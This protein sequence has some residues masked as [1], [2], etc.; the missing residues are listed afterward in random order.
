MKRPNFENEKNEDRKLKTEKTCF[1]AEVRDKL[2]RLPRSGFPIIRA[3]STFEFIKRDSA[4]RS[5]KDNFAKIQS[6]Y[7][8]GKHL[9]RLVLVSDEVM[10]GLETLKK[11]F[12]NFIEVLCH[13]K[14]HL[15][16][17]TIGDQSV[18]IN[19]I[20]LWG[21]P[22]I[23]KTEFV[24]ALSEVLC[25][26]MEKVNAA[27]LNGALALSGTEPQWGESAPGL[28]AQAMMRSENA[29]FIFYLDELE[30]AF[31]SGSG[32]HPLNALYDLLEERT[33]SVFVDQA[34]T[35][36]VLFDASK[37]IFIASGNGLNTVHEALISRFNVFKIPLPSVEQ[38][39]QIVQGINKSLLNSTDWGH[40]FDSS[41]NAEVIDALIED[42][43][44]VRH[45][46]K[47]LKN[48]Y[49]NAYRNDR[50]FLIVE[51]IESTNHRATPMGFY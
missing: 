29:N 44:S 8:E 15:T 37:I 19:P 5:A 18:Q 48:A 47:S 4:N 9:K 50:N 12:P 39:K 38:M 28:V 41:L 21:E 13:I 36:A 26:G 34:F 6:F 51:D 42:E 7:D 20:Y 46:K 3:E 40:Y 1:L 30:K 43:Q 45:V 24:H 33:A 32:G 14:N 17:K 25:V 27:Q 2:D 11:R 16:L 31:N 22:G 10:E 49:V 35:N 23:G